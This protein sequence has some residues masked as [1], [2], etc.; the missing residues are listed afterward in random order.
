M[1]WSLVLKTLKERWRMAAIFAG[2][3]VLYSLLLAAIYPTVGKMKTDYAKQM[4]K[5]FVKLFGVSSFNLDTFNNYVTLQ[6]LSL[7]WVILVAAFVI[8]M[9][10][11]MVAGELKDG[12]LEF[13][14]SQPVQRWRLMSVQAGLLLA[15]IVGFVLVT[16]GSLIGWAAVFG[17][18]SDYGRFAIFILPA[19][20]LM[21]AIAGYSMLFSALLKDPGAAAMA[22]AGLTLLFYLVNFA[23]SYWK[24]VEFIGWVSIFKYY[25]P[26]E[27][28]QKSSLPARN[29]LVP[30]LFGLACFAGALWAFQRRDVA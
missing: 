18:G 22:A 27:V 13:L 16:V 20:S 2:V 10:R 23:A 1:T 26:L 28:L 8:A 25:Q 4:P 9:A 5:A 6:F 7:M 12:T 11:R 3:I 19:V 24:S 17:V 15:A 21:I 14:L 29:V 30:C